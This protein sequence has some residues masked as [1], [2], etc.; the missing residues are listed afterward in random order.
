VLDLR[1]RR[2]DAFEGAYEPLDAGPRVCAFERGGEVRV[3]VPTR[4]G[5]RKPAF[6]GWRNLLPELP[7]GLYE[8]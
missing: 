3:A 5:A 4:P 8:R 1:R 6:S 2:P 7:V